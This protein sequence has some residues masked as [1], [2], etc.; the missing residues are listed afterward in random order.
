MAPG[1]P[2]RSRVSPWSD[3][4]RR[5]SCQAYR[6]AWGSASYQKAQA[7]R[8]GRQAAASRPAVSQATRAITGVRKTRSAS[9]RSAQCRF[10]R[11]L[12]LSRPVQ[13][14]HRHRFSPSTPP[15]LSAAR[16]TR[17]CRSSSGKA[18]TCSTAHSR[19]NAVSSRSMPFCSQRTR[20]TP[21]CC[22]PWR[23]RFCSVPVERP[24]ASF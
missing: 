24:S 17:S 6:S 7:A 14:L 16:R 18:A 10:T 1:A 3:A 2:C 23:S 11:R 20:D 12:R 19:R 5:V 8:K 13:P 15:G 22:S 9:P 4:A 21:A